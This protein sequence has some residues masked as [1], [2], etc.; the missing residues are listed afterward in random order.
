M[1]ERLA[2]GCRPSGQVRARYSKQPGQRWESVS[3]PLG[4][5]PSATRRP[6]CA[7]AASSDQLGLVTLTALQG[8]LLLTETRRDGQVCAMSTKRE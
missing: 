8:G 7:T 5:R 2:L 4:E 1:S 3:C 6:Q